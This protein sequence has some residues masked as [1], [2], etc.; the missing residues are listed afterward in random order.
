[1]CQF[2]LST[3]RTNT[4]QIKM[5]GFCFFSQYKRVLPQS[6]VPTASDKTI[7]IMNNKLTNILNML[8][9][10]SSAKVL[11]QRPTNKIGKMKSPQLIDALWVITRTEQQ[12]S[13]HNCDVSSIKNVFTA[14]ELSHI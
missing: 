11:V 14:I 9:N 8:N 7:T 12:P 1:M 6:T 13:R 4:V 5:I 10:K 2:H 3:C